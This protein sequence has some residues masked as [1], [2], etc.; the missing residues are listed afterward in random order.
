MAC[1]GRH[2]EAF[3]WMILACVRHGPD[4]QHGYWGSGQSPV[5]RRRDCHFYR[6]IR[7]R[8]HRA[9]ADTERHDRDGSITAI[10]SPTRPETS[11]P[12]SLGDHDI[13]VDPRLILRYEMYLDISRGVHSQCE[14]AAGPRDQCRQPQRRWPT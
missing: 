6:R 7:S 5:R 3:D 1:T 14:A 11:I 9:H 13:I 4:C 10:T 12:F 8:R 2:A